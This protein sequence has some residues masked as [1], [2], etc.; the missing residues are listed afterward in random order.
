ML[1]STLRLG[2]RQLS[3]AS[4]R[5]L[6]P[7]INAGTHLR[8]NQT[9]SGD[10]CVK[11]NITSDGVAVVRFDT[12]G[13]KVNVLSEKF[14]TDLAEVIQDV[15]SNADVKSIVLLSSK[16]GCWIAGAD[17][18]ML[19]AGDTAKKVEEMSANGQ[20]LM[21]HVED[22]KKPFVAAIMGSCLGGGL[23]LA[24]S[25]HYRVAVDNSSTVLGAP[26]V[27]L[28]LLPGAGGTQRLPSL[29]GLPDSLDMMLTGKNIKAGKAKRMGLVD[30]LV[31][32]L[33]P[34]LKPPLENTLQYLEEIAIQTAKNLASGSV[35]SDRSRSWGNMKDLQYK[36][37]TE[38]KFGR[39]FVFK[40]AK[41]TVMKQTGGLY[42]A[43]LKILDVVR[44]GLEEGHQKGFKK[45][46]EEFGEL[47]QTSE[48]K[49][50][51]GL[52]FGQTECKKNPYG[53]PQ[54]PVNTV[55]VIG[56]GLMG[57]GIAQVSLQ[58]GQNVVM[59][60]NILEGLTRGQE[61]IYKGLNGRVKKKAMTSFERDNMM[62]KLS[63]QLDFRNFDKVDMVIEAVFEDLNL[64]HKVIK[65]IEKV[66][67]EHCV[68]ASN[69]SALPIHK[70]AEASIRP[71]KVVGMHYFS[72]VEKMP[73]LEIITTDKT[74]NDTAAA[75]V[76][77]G[78]KQGKTVI[79]VKDGPGFYTTR[80]LAPTL[81]EAVALLQE[82]V[83]P[84][85]LDS[86][87]KQFG[88][89]VGS[90]TLA[91][92]VG[93][94][95]AAHV[96]EDLHKAFGERFGGGNPELLKAMVD[97]GHLGRKSGK[98]F[99]IYSGKSSKR[100]VNGEVEKLLKE[101]AIPKKGSHDPEEIQMR[102]A[103]R[104]VNESILCLQEGILKNPVDGDIGAVFG[105]GFPPFHGGPFRYL[106]V[107][108]AEKFVERMQRLQET[109]GGE[110]FQP[111]Q[112]LLDF[113][114]DPS[115]KFHKR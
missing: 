70:V 53:A 49:A 23:E 79:V 4:R 19:N 64:K 75:A 88:F 55:A 6:L 67:P 29:V 12:P 37:T 113:A 106:D 105:L 14:T 102:L 50:L 28:G 15:E 57:A 54:K 77:V 18:N 31:K 16:P 115:K 72:P 65:E 98:G 68:F 101:F 38:T 44:S 2:I 66:I 43:P 25:C 11:C 93:I 39:D 80:I 94:D 10:S 20:K 111:C 87:T 89:P 86:L 58:K 41:Q 82:G 7:A 103:S 112:M 24:L 13:S 81:A 17:I 74:S 100:E 95:V 3:V 45:E 84:K 8:F 21:Q 78:L 1:S 5:H 90:A 76:S 83:G 97:G 73:L 32:P 56:A 42:P 59:K 85:E 35:K 27:M 91:D 71:E 9:A 69:T 96:A 107:Y 109:V 47:S 92:E 62:S 63:G 99:F 104:F 40:K 60:D 108:G 34:G 46:A 22:S 52:F 30:G 33:G 48:A 114:K 26:E 36:I 61:Q 110:R 51:M